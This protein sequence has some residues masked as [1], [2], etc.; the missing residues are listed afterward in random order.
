MYR[1]GQSLNDDGFETL[2][3]TNNS[4]ARYSHWLRTPHT[5]RKRTHDSASLVDSSVGLTNKSGTISLCRRWYEPPLSN[6]YNA[7]CEGWEPGPPRGASSTQLDMHVKTSRLTGEWDEVTYLSR[8]E[9]TGWHKAPSKRA[10]ELV[11]NP[12]HL[13]QS[14]YPSGAKAHDSARQHRNQV[15]IRSG[16]QLHWIRRHG[17]RGAM[18]YKWAVS[19]DIEQRRLVG[20]HRNS[21]MLG[22]GHEE[23]LD[24]LSLWQTWTRL[25]GGGPPTKQVMGSPTRTSSNLDQAAI[26]IS[27]IPVRVQPTGNPTVQSR[28]EESSIVPLSAMAS[29]R[30][31]QARSNRA[32]VL[33]GINSAPSVNV[34]SGIRFPHNAKKWQLGGGKC[35]GEDTLEGVFAMGRKEAEIVFQ[36]GQLI[37]PFRGHSQS[38]RPTFNRQTWAHNGIPEG[39]PGCRYINSYHSTE[40]PARWVRM[41]PHED[42]ANCQLRTLPASQGGGLGFIAIEEIWHGQEI[43]MV[44]RECPM[45]LE[46]AALESP[47]PDIAVSQEGYTQADPEQEVATE[48]D[49]VAEDTM[50]SSHQYA[51]LTD[52]GGWKMHEPSPLWTDGILPQQC[53]S[54]PPVDN[55]PR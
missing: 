42:L 32:T 47:A 55:L 10:Y 45:L 26:S 12:I 1:E 33:A 51:V 48:A 38:T 46:E 7:N 16:I 35:P 15:A 37:C 4:D 49:S 8:P 21:S 23:V 27:V 6:E 30:G 52:T 24:S 14:T 39:S 36:P 34:P 22:Q 29:L 17:K 54:P 18:R 2:T 43:L 11:A 5:N 19:T 20:P 41:A 3:F 31:P 28:S 40:S 44:N 13:D 9:G 53:T 50:P 25:E